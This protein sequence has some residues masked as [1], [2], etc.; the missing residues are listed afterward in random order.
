MSSGA[1][2]DDKEVIALLKSIDLTKNDMLDIS[3]PMALTIVNH[4]RED[5]PVDTAATKTS[6]E[7]EVIVSTK[8]LVTQHIGPSTDYSPT[9]EYG[10]ADQPNRALQPFVRPSVFGPNGRK[11]VNVGNANFMKIIV[12]KAKR[13]RG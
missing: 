2:V 12:E 1:S 4:Q 9:L 8:K 13:K 5:V 3:T 6:I 10:R 7:P 11:V